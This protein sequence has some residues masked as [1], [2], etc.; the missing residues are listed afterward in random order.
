MALYVI[1][2]AH[3]ISEWG[4][5]F[6]PA[7][8]EIKNSLNEVLMKDNRLH[9]LATTA[10]AN[11]NVINDLQAQFAEDLTVQRG[12]LLRESLVLEVL[13]EMSIAQR[14]AWVGKFIL[15]Q[16]GA[17]IVYGLT[18]NTC[19][20]L[21]SY[22]S[23]LGI[24]ACAYSSENDDREQIENAFYE[25][26]LQVLVATSALGMGYDKPDISFVI[27]LQKP[28]SMLEYYQQIGRA[29]RNI[30]VAK[31]F[32][33]RGPQDK[34]LNDY[35]INKSAP[36]LEKM[37]GV[38]EKIAQHHS[39]SIKQIGLLINIKKGEIEAILKHL[40][41]RKLIVKSGYSYSRTLKADDLDDYIKDKER[42]IEQRQAYDN[43]MTDFV[44]YKGCYMEFISHEL[45][46]PF[47]T[48][49]GKCANCTGVATDIEITKNDEA[50]AEDFIERIYLNE[51]SC[52][53]IH[54]KKKYPSGTYIEASYLNQ[55]GYFLSIYNQGLGELVA[56]GKYGNNKGF[57]ERLVKEMGVMLKYLQKNDKIAS[58]D[59][60]IAYVPSLRDVSL[61]KNFA[62]A[63]AS[64]LKLDCVSI[65]R[66][67]KD[68][69]QQKKMEN[70]AFQYNNVADAFDIDPSLQDMVR[71]KNVY[72]IDDMV[73]SGWTFTVCG[74]VL[75][76]NASAKSVTP[77]ALANTATKE[78]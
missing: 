35:F 42:I 32:L 3:C 77:L 34:K 36:E 65:L 62:E 60:V 29:G 49:C 40:L 19:N 22:L 16:Q 30:P 56:Q 1:D 18:I 43:T 45:N 13:P 46:D 73:D 39:I 25:N 6:R 67:V 2:E 47:V 20:R 8:L 69:E 48:K 10:T 9:V 53:E 58:K 4:H 31:V 37:R 24:R 27:H 17:G 75:L 61:V 7:F 63:L 5:D 72:L 28:T 23:K 71:N 44:N 41:A 33:L 11:D 15:K 66:K 50:K 70:S 68:T 55:T 14:Y 57:N 76:Q 78:S 38:L 59:V 64:N 74:K 54:V 26:K 52:C 21:A 51:L 12:P